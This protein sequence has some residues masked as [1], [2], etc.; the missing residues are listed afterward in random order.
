MPLKELVC[1]FRPDARRPHPSP[2]PRRAGNDQRQAGEGVLGRGRGPGNRDGVRRRI[3]RPAR[4]LR[5]EASG[6]EVSGAELTVVV[7]T[8]AHPPERRGGN[9]RRCRGC[10][11]GTTS[12][13]SRRVLLLPVPRHQ[14]PCGRTVSGFTCPLSSKVTTH[15]RSYTSFLMGSGLGSIP[16]DCSRSGISP[17]CQQIST[18]F[19]SYFGFEYSSSATVAKSLFLIFL[20]IS[21]FSAAASEETVSTGRSL[22]TDAFAA[23]MKSGVGNGRGRSAVFLNSSG[24]ASRRLSSP[25]R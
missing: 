8:A 23:K 9:I 11:A 3:E 1:D 22:S 6:R 14:R 20:S 7:R 2:S 5:P 10:A 13:G 17:W 4:R 18:V 24:S 21:S 15:T 19:P 25:R 12:P 16:S